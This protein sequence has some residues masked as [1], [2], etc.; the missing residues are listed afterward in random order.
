MWKFNEMAMNEANRV[1]LARVSGWMGT[2]TDTHCMLLLLTV[3]FTCNTYV[4]KMETGKHGLSIIFT[5]AGWFQNGCN[6]AGTTLSAALINP[7][8]SA[9]II[10][11]NR[12][13]W[14]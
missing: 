1:K 11:T 7:L 12:V 14:S 6:L 10:Y 8:N 2:V 13:L 4:K 9:A 5:P 3:H